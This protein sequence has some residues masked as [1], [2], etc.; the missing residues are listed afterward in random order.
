MNL[1]N[2]IYYYFTCNNSTEAYNSKDQNFNCNKLSPSEVG[3]QNHTIYRSAWLNKNRLSNISGSGYRKIIL[4]NLCTKW[5][6]REAFSCYFPPINWF[7]IADRFSGTE[8]S[9][10]YRRRGRNHLTLI[11]H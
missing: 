8:H 1:I 3:L 9:I 11:K 7:G 6:E 5:V 10:K 2:Y 4:C